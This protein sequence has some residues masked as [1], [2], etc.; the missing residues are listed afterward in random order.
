RFQELCSF[1]AVIPETALVRGTKKKRGWRQ[2]PEYY[3]VSNLQIAVAFGAT[4]FECYIEW[5][6]KKGV[7]QRQPIIPIWNDVRSSMLNVQ[8]NQEKAPDIEHTP[9]SLSSN[10]QPSDGPDRPVSGSD[11]QGSDL[12]SLTPRPWERDSSHQFLNSQSVCTPKSIGAPENWVVYACSGVLLFT[13]PS[14]VITY[15]TK[16]KTSGQINLKSAAHN[17]SPDGNTL[18]RWIFDENGQP[19]SLQAIDVKSTQK[20]AELQQSHTF[21]QCD[22]LNAVWIDDVTIYIP[23]SAEGVI[24]PWNIQSAVLPNNHLED[25]EVV[26]PLPSITC[27]SIL[28]FEITKSRSWWTATGITFDPP[29][30][31][32]EVHDV[33]NDESRIVEGMVSCIAEVGVNDEENALL[34]SAGVTQDYK[35]QLRVQQ[36]DLWDSGHHFPSIDVKIDTIEEKDYPRDI[37]VLH[38]LPIV[39]VMTEKCYGYF[40]ELNTGAYLYSQAQKSYQVCPGQSNKREIWLWSHEESDVKVLRVNEGDLIGYCRTVLK[41]DSLASAIASRTGLSEDVILESM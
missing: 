38:P 31:L 39:A 10:M 34:V 13:L 36:L 4:E 18:V 7:T 21:Q 9:P 20:I 17:L 32:I 23:V 12:A 8:N 28:K 5:R 2:S 11:M 3:Y 6:D 29:S 33:K 14:G 30:G 37:T 25:L 22:I 24:V 16:S 26:E 1:K 40:F 35:L 41:D 15:N 27:H 19:S